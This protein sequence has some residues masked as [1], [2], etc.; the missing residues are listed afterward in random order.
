[1]S[2]KRPLEE[3][4]KE[5]EQQI[6]GHLFKPITQQDREKKTNEIK[7]T[8][9]EQRKKDEEV[10]KKEEEES[11]DDELSE[12]TGRMSNLG[13]SRKKRKK[14]K[15]KTNRKKHT[16]KRKHKKRKSTRKK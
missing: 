2:K 13:S 11:D 4:Q 1:M 14:R 10:N 12:I 6:P 7:A 3:I 16:K 9:L 8:I 5:V 15:P